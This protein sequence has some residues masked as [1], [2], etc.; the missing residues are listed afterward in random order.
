[1]EWIIGLLKKLHNEE[2][3]TIIELIITISIVAIAA[4]LSGFG[5]NGLYGAQVDS[6]TYDIS[7]ELRNARYR[8]VSEFDTAYQVVLTYDD[9]D[10]K[11]G[12]SLQ[13]FKAGD[14]AP[15]E[16][17]K[18]SYKQT[19]RIMREDLLGNWVELKEDSIKIQDNPERGCFTFNTTTGG[20]SE[21]VLAS[22]STK[23][24]SLNLN[25]GGLGK[26]KIVNTRNN[27]EFRFDVVG[28]TG[29]VV[30]YD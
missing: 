26:F 13:K 20:I 27:E 7:A 12:Y 25:S 4:G 1:M 24:E 6:M 22:T 8:S 28:L 23:V 18:Q 14:I 30:V 10:N 19:L 15:T 21:Y 9:T 29:R 16:V 11:Y 2:G 5:L 3:F 17:S